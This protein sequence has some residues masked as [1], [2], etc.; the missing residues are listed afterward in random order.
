M[1]QTIINLLVGLVQNYPWFTS[2]VMVLGVARAVFKPAVAVYEAYVME[3]PS[4]EDN[5]AF[6]KFKTG[7][8]YF[9]LDYLFSI[10]IPKP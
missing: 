9:V 1:E 10:K 5:A 6:E 8:V 7:K 4:T 2:V 3:T